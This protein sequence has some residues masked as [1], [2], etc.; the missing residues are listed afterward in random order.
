MVVPN[1]LKKFQMLYIYCLTTPKGSENSVN[2]V[3]NL[4][5]KPPELPPLSEFDAKFL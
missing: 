4:H 2:F 3:D 5:K 1:L